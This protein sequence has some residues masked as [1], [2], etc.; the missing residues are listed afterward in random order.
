MISP[1]WLDRNANGTQRI[2]MNII[3]AV[4]GEVV[5]IK[6]W[7]EGRSTIIDVAQTVGKA[8]Q[9]TDAQVAG[10]RLERFVSLLSVLHSCKE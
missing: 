8:D 4:R 3:V 2:N 7:L 1:T 6:G 10:R 5:G 9:S